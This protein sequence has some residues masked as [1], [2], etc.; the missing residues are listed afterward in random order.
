MAVARSVVFSPVGGE[1]IVEMAVRRLGEAIAVGLI[2]V[3]EQL[4]T[5]MELAEQLGIATSSLREALAVLSEGGYVETRRGRG[6]G[7][8]VCRPILAQA[9]S[10]SSWRVGEQLRHRSAAELRDLCV[11]QIAVSG[12]AGALAADRRMAGEAT[13]LAALADE[14]D[15]LADDASFRRADSRFHIAIAGAARSPRLVAFE[16]TLQAESHDLLA[17]AP[18]PEGGHALAIAEHR[19]IA[20]AITRQDPHMARAVTERHL[21]RIAAGLEARREAAARFE[22]AHRE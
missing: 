12:T 15:A 18:D 17:R 7:T 5:E 8:F 19:E 13:E 16:T 3:G 2:D 4:P 11:F 10:S 9:P 6:G 20:L 22:D 14:M 21:R 1:G